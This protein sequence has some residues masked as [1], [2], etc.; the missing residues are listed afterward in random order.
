MI[1]AAANRSG[2]GACW[3]EVPLAPPGAVAELGAL[4]WLRVWQVKK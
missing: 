2:R 1:T 4:R 3:E